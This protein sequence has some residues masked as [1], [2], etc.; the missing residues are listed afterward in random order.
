VTGVAAGHCE[1]SSLGG[2]H[3]AHLAPG[4]LETYVDTDVAKGLTVHVLSALVLFG[5]DLTLL[6][7]GISGVNGGDP[8]TVYPSAHLI[9]VRVVEPLAVLS[10]ATGFVLAVLTPWG[11]AKYCWTLIKLSVTVTIRVS[12]PPV[13]RP[14]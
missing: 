4:R 1:P 13:W 12:V 8:L 14:R 3:R 6:V 11:L 10:L 9:G 2:V 7:L 5:A